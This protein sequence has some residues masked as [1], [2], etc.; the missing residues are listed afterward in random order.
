[1]ALLAKLRDT[2]ESTI[3]TGHGDISFRPESRASEVTLSAS[4]GRQIR[5][6]Y[7]YYYCDDTNYGTKSLL[8]YPTNYMVRSL[9][10]APT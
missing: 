6:I 5:S 3:K 10:V 9:L 2:R 7:Y 4:A 1:M 8:G